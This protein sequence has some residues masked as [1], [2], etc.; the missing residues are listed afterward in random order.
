MGEKAKPSTMG[1]YVLAGLFVFLQSAIMPLIIKG[2]DL[3]MRGLV[4]VAATVVMTIKYRR[5]G[6]KLKKTTS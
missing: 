6:E 5:V 3:I 1:L 2:A 4:I